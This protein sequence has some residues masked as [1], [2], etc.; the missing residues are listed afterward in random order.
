[1][2]RPRRLLCGWLVVVAVFLVPAAEANDLPLPT[3][4]PMALS[5]AVVS[6]D[7]NLWELRWGKP[8]S[9]WFVTSDW[10]PTQETRVEGGYQ[11]G[12]ARLSLD[13]RHQQDHS[14]GDQMALSLIARYRF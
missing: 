10:E 5:A 2:Q 9:H 14:R 8:D 11:L 12:R 6:A 13:V 4:Q 7:E 3:E 1:M